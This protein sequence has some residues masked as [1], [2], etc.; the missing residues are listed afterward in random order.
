MRRHT[1]SAAGSLLAIVAVLA[2]PAAVRAQDPTRARIISGA[3]FYSI[4]FDA[5]TGTKSV[6]EMIVPIGLVLPV[7]QRL[8]FDIGTYAVSVE[9]EDENGTT[10]TI[11]GVTDVMVRAG[12]QIK[13]D[14]ATLTFGLSLPTGQ[15]T[16]TRDQLLA[17]G[18]VA[19]DLI[20]FPVTSFG[21]GLTATTG[22]AIAVPAGSWAIGLAGSYRYNASY[23][24]IAPDANDPNPP[25]LTP[26]SEF[27]VRLGA[28][29]L[30]GQ[31]RL[32]MGV[33]YSTF[34]QDEFGA[35]RA[36]PGPRVISQLSWNVPLGNN[37]MSLYFWDVYRGEGDAT[38]SLPS[39]KQNTFA[40]GLVGG[41]R[42]GSGIL[43]PSL[44]FRQQSTETTAAAGTESGTL[45]GIGARYQW[46]LGQ[47][48]TVIPGAR[49]D[50]GSIADIGFTGMSGSL[51]LRFGL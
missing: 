49:F 29:R 30:V 20:P 38:A 35:D 21:A 3:E 41:F 19:S 50:T 10:A 33:T 7:S 44:E 40:V 37:S 31:G 9:R 45:F 25:T 24:P 36:S 47:R 39:F 27:R 46:Q 17:A 14:F 15:G 11:S 12:Y 8:T 18:T 6:R 4:S 22:L 48:F 42:M 43:R 2:A 34:S 32:M 5:G 13:P 23:D 51:G 1:V 26:G 28:D 16:L